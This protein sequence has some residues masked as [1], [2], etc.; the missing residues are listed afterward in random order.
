MGSK[1]GIDLTTRINGEAARAKFDVEPPSAERCAEIEKFLRENFPTY[2]GCDFKKGF[3]AV[4]LDKGENSGREILEKLRDSG[5]LSGKFRAAAIFDAE[6]DLS[7]NSKLLWKV[8][9]NVDPA[10]DIL[11]SPDGLC[12]VDACKKNAADGYP[13]E[14]P[15]DLSFDK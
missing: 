13:R 10:R 6:I 2:G 8:F 9:N 5:L 15:D 3:L 11:I 4:A 12:L 7:D 1:I 14:W